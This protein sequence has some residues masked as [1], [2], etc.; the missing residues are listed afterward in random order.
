[1][2]E[3]GPDLKYEHP[4]VGVGNELCKICLEAKASHLSEMNK[5][6]DDDLDM[7]SDDELSEE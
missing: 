7:I 3:K 1:L 2:T 4:F 5:D 6:E